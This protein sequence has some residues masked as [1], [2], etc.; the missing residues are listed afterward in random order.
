MPPSLNPALLLAAALSFIAAL[1]H[2][3]CILG[4]PAWYRFFGAGERMAQAAAR[5]SWVP[6]GVTAGITLVLLAWAAYALSAAGAVPRLP[7]LKAAIVAITVVYLLR[8]LVLVPALV[9]KPTH[10]TPFVVWSSLICLGYG[11][12]HLLGVVQVWGRL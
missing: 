9:F 8:G 2:L 11:L 1:L 3:G 12:V 6:A 7:L 4:G 10:V 5:G